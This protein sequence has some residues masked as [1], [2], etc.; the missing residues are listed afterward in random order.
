MLFTFAHR[1]FDWADYTVKVS[2][3]TVEHVSWV[4]RDLV[5]L[6][7][8]EFSA[9]SKRQNTHARISESP[10]RS[11]DRVLGNPIRHDKQYLRKVR[12]KLKLPYQERYWL[13]YLV[14]QK[15][16][17]T[18]QV[19][20]AKSYKKAVKLISKLAVQPLYLCTVDLILIENTPLKFLNTCINLYQQGNM[21]KQPLPTNLNCI[22]LLLT[23][24]CKSVLYWTAQGLGVRDYMSTITH[25]LENFQTQTLKQSEWS[26]TCCTFAGLFFGRR[27]SGC[28]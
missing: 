5:K 1:S 11:H 7:S 22:R 20:K 2:E 27:K 15:A 3:A 19:N 17:Q 8:S 14:W 13:H 23:K 21:V 9:D 10:R 16:Y 24:S 18:S 6:C 26:Q 4:C 25:K 12:T 28:Q